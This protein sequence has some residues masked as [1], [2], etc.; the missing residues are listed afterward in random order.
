MYP[1]ASF[2]ALITYSMR[3]YKL[4][5]INTYFFPFSIYKTNTYKMQKRKAHQVLNHS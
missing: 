5:E 1:V 2:G 4:L 3:I